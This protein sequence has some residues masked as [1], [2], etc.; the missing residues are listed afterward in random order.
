MAR[1]SFRRMQE[2]N[3]PGRFVA[4]PVDA[5]FMSFVAS[6]D[7]KEM[8]RKN[9]KPIL[10]AGE[11]FDRWG[12]QLPDAG[13]GIV[14]GFSG[15]LDPSALLDIFYEE[16]G[17]ENIL[18]QTAVTSWSADAT[19]V[20][21]TIRETTDRVFTF[22]GFAGPGRLQRIRST[23]FDRGHGGRSGPHRPQSGEPLGNLTIGYFAVLDK[24]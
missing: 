8:A 18:W 24:R 19:G 1:E 22:V 3:R 17:E 20:N 12:V 11:I 6:D 10:N 5:L 2:M 23:Q 7:F 13:V 4:G 15:I 21:V 9:D 16:I 14:D